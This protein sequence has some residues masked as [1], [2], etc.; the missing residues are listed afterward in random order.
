[1]IVCN[2]K[3]VRNPRGHP[4]FDFAIKTKVRWSK[5]LHEERNCPNQILLAS[6]DTRTCTVYNLAIYVE[7]FLS[8]HP[9]VVLLFTEQT[10]GPN[11]V[12]NLISRYQSQI[13]LQDFK[14]L[15]DEGDED[16]VGTH[17]YCKFPS[18]YA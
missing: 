14:R 12:K 7:E 1:M 16:G 10:P 18:T 17:S 15:A 9:R 13:W 8:Q 2:F 5:N 3:V 11:A 4:S 6:M